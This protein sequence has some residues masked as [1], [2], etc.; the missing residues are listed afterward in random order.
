MRYEADLEGFQPAVCRCEI[1]I[2]KEQEKTNN[3][4]E[5]QL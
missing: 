4:Q 2:A 3:E 5:I 1:V